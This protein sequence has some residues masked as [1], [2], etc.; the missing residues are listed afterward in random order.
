MDGVWANKNASHPDP[1]QMLAV[2]V[3]W[4][5]CLLAR[6]MFDIHWVPG[7]KRESLERWDGYLGG[8]SGLKELKS[9]CVK[10]SEGGRKL[11][12]RCPKMKYVA[13]CSRRT[14]WGCVAT[15]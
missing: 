13:S 15:M 4:T 8:V 6:H 10:T 9:D 1:N 7:V 11:Y 12:G 14:L 3:G 5:G 2:R